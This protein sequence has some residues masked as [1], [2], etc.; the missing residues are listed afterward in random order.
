[1]PAVVAAPTCGCTCTD[2][3]LGPDD[4]ASVQALRPA[5]PQDPAACP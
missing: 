5:I 2:N 3:G 4:S 1:M